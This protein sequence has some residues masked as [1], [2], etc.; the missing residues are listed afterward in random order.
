MHMRKLALLAAVVALAACSNDSTSPNGSV[1][2]SYSLRTINGNSLPYTF[3]NGSVIVTD[4]L[5]LRSDGSYVDIAQFS[6]GATATEQ[7]LWSINNNLIT[8]NDQTDGIQY[9]GSVS[10][11]VLT[12]S[13]PSFS[14]FNSSVTEV[15]QKD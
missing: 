7:G 15:Y 14:G 5:S 9:T 6:N 10:G 3:T 1:V 12:E 8:F 11:A 13:F 2:G 4:Q